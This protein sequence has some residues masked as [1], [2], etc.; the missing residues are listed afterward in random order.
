MLSWDITGIPDDLG[1]DGEEFTTYEEY[2]E[3]SMRHIDRI[4]EKINCEIEN[5]LKKIDEK[6]NTSYAPTGSLRS[7]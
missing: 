5:F 6:Y 4:I 7:Y 2:V 3:D 1:Y